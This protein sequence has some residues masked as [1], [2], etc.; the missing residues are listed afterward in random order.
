[1]Q[2]VTAVQAIENKLH[3]G[4]PLYRLILID[5]NLQGSCDAIQTATKI[6]RLVKLANQRVGSPNKKVKMPLMACIVSQGEERDS[7]ETLR[8]AGF[9]S[10][11]IKPVSKNSF[12]KLLSCADLL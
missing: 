2:G 7:R 1:M 3:C 11:I 12:Q 8:R 10:V 9:N 6:K 5:K 4:S